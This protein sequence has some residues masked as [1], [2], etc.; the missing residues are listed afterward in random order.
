MLTTACKVYPGI[1]SATTRY[2]HFT[3]A[4]DV[5]EHV[6]VTWELVVGDQSC[7]TCVKDDLNVSE[8]AALAR[9]PLAPWLSDEPT[10]MLLMGRFS[11][12]WV[13]SS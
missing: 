4:P 7:R 9:M 12:T 5:G 2:L 10:E 11:P 3:L 8:A 13:T 6:A 1:V